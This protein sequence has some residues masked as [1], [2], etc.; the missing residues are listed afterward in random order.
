[1]SF[2]IV[3]EIMVTKGQIAQDKTNPDSK[4]SKNSAGHSETVFREAQDVVRDDDVLQVNYTTKEIALRIF[5]D[6]LRPHKMVLVLSTLA[7]MFAAMTTG[8][9]PYFL[10]MAADEI[11]T[12]KNAALIPYLTAGVVAVTLLKALS[13]F[14]SKVAISYLGLKFI[15][16]IRIKMFERLATA[17]LSWIENV[18]SG[19]FL[20]G[21]LNDVNMVR[22]MASRTM[23][24]LV[25]SFGKV[26]VLFGYMFWLDWK[27][28]LI[29]MIFLPAGLFMM[30]KQKRN[31]HRSTTKSLQ[32]TG[33]L[34]KLISQ[35]LRGTR[36]VRAYNQEQQEI[37]RASKVINRTMEFTMRGERA[38][39]ISGPIVEMLAGLG[40]ALV[41]YISSME[42]VSGNMTLG[43]F[44]GFASATMLMYQPLKSLAT[45]QT[46]MQEGVAAAS[47]V[48]GIIDKPQTLLEIKEAGTLKVVNNTITFDKVTFGYKVGVAIFRDFSLDIPK[49]KTVALVG[50]S[51]AGKSTV[52]NLV[53]RFFDPQ[54]GKVLIDG[55][56]ISQVTLK[57]L[58]DS[59]ALVTQDP[60]LFDDT[61]RANIL[62]G[63][64]DASE[65]Q[66]RQAAK[67]AAADKFIEALP[68]GY[69]TIVGEAGNNLSGGE[70]QRIAIA[71]AF[72]KD[73]PFLL[74]DEPTSALDTKSE[75][76]VQH[77]LDHLREGRTVLMI[78]HR[79]STI[80]QADIICVISDGRV[81]EQGSHKAL[82]DRDGY[83]KQ[84]H[85][86][87]KA[88]G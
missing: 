14:G 73:A 88:V 55:Q 4:K 48:Y 74:L 45:L 57:S 43:D 6:H 36:I 65:G 83:Y 3:R 24:A 72:L 41:I 10:K 25:E 27:M 69:D 63:N 54:S 38:K 16:D 68:R 75:A 23:V 32:E 21:F 64:P 47:R 49:G 12:A 85:M 17:D 8:A 53:L 44:I 82:M 29:I 58:R 2:R 52:F 51:G 39:A 59:I 46:V 7:M 61:V 18:H 26:V 62:Y 35:I 19:R 11:F 81:I 34:A 66:V 80:E 5:N 37:R 71:R 79:L 67:E 20:A 30:T 56:D 86:T 28:A 78:A 9:I 87:G 77:A 15:A 84:L 22:N 13:E 60:I 1:M 33:D 76:I 40:F 70:R 42:G 31:M 50:P